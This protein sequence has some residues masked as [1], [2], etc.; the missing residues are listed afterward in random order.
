MKFSIVIPNWNGEKLL[1]KNLPA[2]FKTKADEVIVID[3]GS[4]DGSVALLNS[5]RSQNSS[6]KIIFNQ[7]NQGFVR[8]VNQ[9]VKAAN[10]QIVVLL[11][12][13]VV[14]EP[15]FLKP[16]VNHF[17]NDK[18]FAV[19][20]NEPQWSWARGK[21]SSGF[22]EHEIGEKSSSSHV[23]FWACGGSGA[24]RRS[25][26]L[27]LGGMDKLF[28]PFYWEDTDLSYRAW[29]RGYQVLWEPKSIVHHQH[30]GTIGSN[31]SPK[32]V[33]FISQRNQ[34]LFIWK[35]I[36]DFKMLLEHK[37]NLFR[38]LIVN[39]GYWR[40]FLAAWLRF[41]LILPKWLKELK[42]KKVSDS[43]IFEQFN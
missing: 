5:F 3:N 18:V 17:E 43:K 1:S 8:A 12:N 33:D 21:W 35:N 19:S 28:A 36:T 9:G 37:M 40:P 27:K 10:G 15:E 24:F 31:F 23:S 29:K 34:L 7:T 14:P 4:T 25:V 20:L 11:N 13:D 39:P 26:W 38:K 41:C 2:V 32:Y 16:L 22:V 42:D 30:E 6:L